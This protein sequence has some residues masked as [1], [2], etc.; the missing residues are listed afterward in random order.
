MHLIKIAKDG[1]LTLTRDL[2]DDIP[3][4]AFLSHRWRRDVDEPT[5]TDIATGSGREKAGYAKVEFCAS[6]TRK[7]NLEYFWIDT[8]CIDRSNHTELSEAIVS[9][10]SWY[11][12]AVKCYVYL[13]DVS[14]S[15]TGN[16]EGSWSSAFCNSEWFR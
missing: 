1:S 14:V 5:F 8:C 13:G 6:Q 4:Y 3:Q 10:F 16:I 7:D 9:M 12:E 15:K 11:R 2:I